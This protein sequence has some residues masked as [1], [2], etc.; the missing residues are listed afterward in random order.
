MKERKGMPPGL[1]QFRKQKGDWKNPMSSRGRLSKLRDNGVYGM[2]WK[3]GLEREVGAA[4]DAS[5]IS[6]VVLAEAFLL[7]RNGI[8]QH[9]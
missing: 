1:L 2:I 3:T 9:Q 7:S 5:E 8:I 6:E 4:A